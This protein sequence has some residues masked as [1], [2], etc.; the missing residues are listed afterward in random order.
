M[1]TEALAHLLCLASGI[2]GRPAW[3]EA[4]CSERAEMIESAAVRHSVDPILMVALDVWECDLQDRDNPVYEVVR[5]KKRLVGYD[6]CPM[7]VRILDVGE[8]S[9]HGAASLY[10]LAA[11]KLARWSRWHSRSRHSGHHFVA[12][13]NPGNPVY[14]DQVL[15][16]GAMLGGRTVKRGP[17]LTARTL[18]ILR[19]L[20]RV[21]S[22]R[23]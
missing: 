5:G 20:G 8:R 18:E 21:L 12:H 17:N 13:Y 7:G 23:S 11:S 22:R 19:R 15:A 3:S 16:I 14:A 1:T 10:E 9:R 4:K 2:F 6:A